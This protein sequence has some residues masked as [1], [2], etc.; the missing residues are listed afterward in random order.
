MAQP[1]AHAPE[2]GIPSEPP[3]VEHM[4][5]TDSAAEGAA[6]P[7]KESGELEV[8]AVAVGGYLSCK[9]L[10]DLDCPYPGGSPP[11]GELP[12]LEGVNPR[13]LSFLHRLYQ[14]GGGGG[15]SK[16]GSFSQAVSDMF[17]MA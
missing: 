9:P 6:S 7:A 10:C 15:G 1:A 14:R 8:G 2:A 5:S 4:L 11:A 16:S 13:D 17:R 12:E 3:L